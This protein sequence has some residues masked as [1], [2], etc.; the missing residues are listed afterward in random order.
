MLDFIK[1]NFLSLCAYAL[2]FIAG[3]TGNPWVILIVL[4]IALIMESGKE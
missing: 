1:K 3:Y 2:V 4:C